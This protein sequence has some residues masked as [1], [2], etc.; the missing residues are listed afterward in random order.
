MDKSIKLLMI[1]AFFHIHILGTMQAQENHDLRKIETVINLTRFFDWSQNESFNHS[2]KMLYV[3][4]DIKSKINF[5]MGNQTSA[6]YKDW[7]VVCSDKILDFDNG[8]VVFI[9]KSKEKYVPGII[10]LS[11]E[12]NILTI[13]EN[14]DDFCKR[15]GMINIK[16]INGQPKFEINY[17]IIQ[18]KSLDISSKLLALSK[19][20]QQ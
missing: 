2:G 14:N 4:T 13:A 3:L 7:K 20:Y 6:N 19:I 5:E 16:G 8:S 9:T 17:R 11:H 12:K 15:G 1:F 18:D 10:V